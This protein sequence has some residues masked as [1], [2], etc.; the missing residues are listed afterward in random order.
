MKTE[1]I[2]LDTFV[3]ERPREALD[4][5]KL[6]KEETA[7]TDRSKTWYTYFT[8]LLMGVFF[9]LDTN[10]AQIHLQFSENFDLALMLKLL[11]AVTLIS[12]YAMLSRLLIFRRRIRVFYDISSRLFPGK[13]YPLCAYI[14]PTHFMLAERLLNIYRPNIEVVTNNAMVSAVALLLTL[15]PAVLTTYEYVIVVGH[16]GLN[17]GIVI[18]SLIAGIVLIGQSAVIAKGTYL[19]RKFYPERN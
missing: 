4:Y 11:P 6:L 14:L 7:K 16:Y 3:K 2:E 13:L 18:A 17:D 8:W 10:L 1:Q 19:D 12:Y 15:S 9:L 5:L